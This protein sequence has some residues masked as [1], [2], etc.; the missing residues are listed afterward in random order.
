M[1]DKKRLVEAIR[2][3]LSGDGNVAELEFKCADGTVACIQFPTASSSSVMLSIERAIGSLFE[4][5]REMLKGGPGSFVP[6]DAKR[7]S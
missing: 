6:V 4:Q 3:G 5:Q 1:T 7:V 2:A